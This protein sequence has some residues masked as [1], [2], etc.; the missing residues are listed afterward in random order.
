MNGSVTLETRIKRRVVPPSVRPSV[1]P[2]VHSFV[3]LF[4]RYACLRR[5]SYGERTAMLHRYLKGR[6]KNQGS[7]N[8]YTKF[9]K[10]I[11]RK[12]VKIIAT[13]SYF[14]A[15]MHQFDP[16]RLSVRSFVS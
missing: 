8:K 4:V 1:R 6:D 11:I 16:R 10:L 3:C 9:G 13:M 2:C 14:K 7:T 5:P 12:I 15:K